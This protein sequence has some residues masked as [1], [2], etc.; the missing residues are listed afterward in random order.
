MGAAAPLTLLILISVRN[1]LK[2]QGS[3]PAKS[4]E[5]IQA[6]SHVTLKCVG[7]GTVKW[8]VQGRENR[9]TNNDIIQIKTATYGD[10]RT[11]RCVYTSPLST[12]SASVHLFVKDGS[13]YWNPLQINVLAYEGQDALIPCLLTD[14]SIPDS[15]VSLEDAD[16]SGKR[17]NTSFDAKKGFTIRNV[18]RDIS[19]ISFQCVA[20]VN[21]NKKISEDLIRINTRTVQI[22]PT[23][24]LT[25]YQHI[26]IQ[27][28]IF[29]AT[30]IAKS[31]V[32]SSI[33]WEG[34]TKNKITARTE[35]Y[36]KSDGW[37]T[38]SKL[39]ML[40]VSFEDSGN[41]TCIART[42]G[43]SNRATGN[44]QVIEK[45]FINL[46][47]M[48]NRSMTLFKGDSVDLPV[49]VE[50]YPSQLS[51]KWLHNNIGYTK[52]V[53]SLSTWKDNG[54][55]RKKGTLTLNRLNE[56][57]IGTYTLFVN[58]S[59]TSAS[60]SFEIKLYSIPVVDMSSYTV[61][62]TQVVSCMSQGFTL[63]TIEWHQ[64]SNTS[65]SDED[66][67]HLSGD[68]ILDV[69]EDRVISILS[70]HDNLSNTTVFC[71]ASN[72]AGNTTAKILFTNTILPSTSESRAEPQQFN[73]ILIGV[74]GAAVFFLLLS[75]FFFYKYKQTP[76]YEIR[77]QMVQMSE[78]NQYICID[79]TQLPYNE[80]WEFPRANLQFGKTIGAG[81]FGKVMEA[82]AFGMGKDDSALRVAVKMLKPS[83]HTD[84]KE[85]LM[86]ELKILSHL[87]NHGNIVNL[88]GACTSGGPILVI[89]EYCQHG[90]LL[91]FMRRK[92]EL[93]NNMFTA[94]HT[95]S[96][97]DY[98]NM[99]VD[100]K[101]LGSDS[102]LGSEMKD[103]YIDMKP[104]SNM[105]STPENSLEEVEED[106]DDHLPL[107]LHDLLNFSLQVAQGM[108]FLASKNCIH[109]DV[110]ARNVLITHGRV[111]K[112][113]DFG[114]AR[115]IE[116][117]SNYV[118]KGN[119]RLPVK[120]MAPESI[121]DC[122][123]TVQSDVW[124][125]G[126]LLWEIFSLGRSPYPGVIVNR[127]FY[128]MIKDGYKMDCPDFAPLDVYRI[129]KACWDL[130]PTHR[131]TFSQITDLINRQMNLITNQEYAN[132]IPDQQAEECTDTK[133]ADS[134]TPLIKGNNY[135]FC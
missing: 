121:F 87:G 108:S 76:K 50:A 49:D 9:P 25:S 44:L 110:A 111:A 62:D 128:K 135:Q 12:E 47:T 61:N 119:A 90:D 106:M 64:C 46:S 36:Y 19:Q 13:N 40:N 39:T 34:S 8:V 85:A 20:R 15:A 51:W 122:I 32:H 82:T 123:Y 72:I 93:M 65:C 67:V 33:K 88:L 107:D 125:Y 53:S 3:V 18:Q 38:S 120:W 60:L 73:L 97:G 80:K 66:K 95:D 134:Q 96:N 24:S 69:Q 35:V 31:N 75:V 105:G 77:W 2:N 118:V 52:N 45:A 91:N 117:D 59:K 104:I 1:G 132:I 56:N 131:P 7:N 10:T 58:N 68:Q 54:P 86:S 27:G 94:V 30:C 17:L 101:Y 115:D 71:T 57:E 78:G 48:K 21:G 98:K 109:R 89:T 11:Y 28:E 124:S 55:Y 41:Y 129:M 79:P 29:E 23:V 74:T 126:I 83:A 4:E 103:S 112:I 63:P 26:R 70:P 37:I 99:A 113:C 84:E 130:E 100:Q 116:N 6:G 92:A 16:N 42:D 81:A 5:I 43:G 22:M 102:G 114:L 127:K 133:C 14:P